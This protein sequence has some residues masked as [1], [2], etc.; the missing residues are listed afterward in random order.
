[1]IRCI[2][3]GQSSFW[4]PKWLILFKGS[5]RL[6]TK[7]HL[8]QGSWNPDMWRDMSDPLFYNDLSIFAIR[9][10]MQAQATNG[11]ANLVLALEA[12]MRRMRSRWSRPWWVCSVGTLHRPELEITKRMN[13]RRSGLSKLKAPNPRCYGPRCLNCRF[14]LQLGKPDRS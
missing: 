2:I 5:T 8:S 9:Y 3:F 12:W 7:E 4:D 13:L 6:Q 10:F 11:P 14:S 1:M